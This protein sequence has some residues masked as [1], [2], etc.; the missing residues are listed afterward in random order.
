MPRE[1]LTVTGVRQRWES[2]IAEAVRMNGFVF[3]SAITG[4]DIETGAVDTDPERQIADAFRNVRTFMEGAG[5]RQEDVAMVH[6]YTVDLDDRRWID[7]EWTALFPDEAN[8]PA[9]H[10]VVADLASFN[11]DY[12]LQVLLIAADPQA[13]A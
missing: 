12:R 8:R 4:A 13:R 2:P 6:L 1:N 5:I 11:P 7:V 9:R 10:A 3:T